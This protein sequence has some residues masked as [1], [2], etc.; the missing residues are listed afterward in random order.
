MHCLLVLAFRYV[1]SV[2]I[3]VSWELF[4]VLY[5][6]FLTVIT[7]AR[8]K[9]VLSCRHKIELIMES[10]RQKIPPTHFLSFPLYNEEIIRRLDEFKST[11]LETCSQVLCI[12]ICCRC[13]CNAKVSLKFYINSCIHLDQ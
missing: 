1:I 9:D 6:F 10:S 2:M 13:C 8:K 5:C 12:E 7:G 4:N 3:A 11:A